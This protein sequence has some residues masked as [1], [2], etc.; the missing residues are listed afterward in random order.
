MSTT[1]PIKD[2]H[3]LERFKNYYLKKEIPRNYL[4]IVI[5]LNTALRIS[6]ILSL[7]WKDVYNI[8]EGKYKNHIEITEQ[9]TGKRNIVALNLAV[10]HALEQLVLSEFENEIF[11]KPEMF[12]F[13]SLRNPE[14][15]N[16]PISRSQA[17]RIIK[18]A[19]KDVGLAEHISCHSLRKTFGYFA[20]KQ[21]IP[22]AMLMNIYNHSSYQ[23]TKRYLGIEQEDKDAVFM[24]IKL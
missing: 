23:I 3:Q 9:K 21:G 12:I 7:K 24:N 22:P 6:D 5:G 13:R 1:H 14:N 15:E 2:K 16:V 11:I 17:F 18:E 19:A 4:L 8:K 20:W 10:T